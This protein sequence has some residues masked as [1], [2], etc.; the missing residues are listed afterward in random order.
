MVDA[1]PQLGPSVHPPKSGAPAHDFAKIGKTRSTD[2]TNTHDVY[3]DNRNGA[4]TTATTTTRS[5][6]EN[7]MKTA[8]ATT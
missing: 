6:E 4:T 7:A 5:L 1:H 3:L 8:S 2:S